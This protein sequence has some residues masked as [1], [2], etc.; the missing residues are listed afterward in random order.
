MTG[1]LGAAVGVPYAVSNA[2]DSWGP[3]SASAPQTA[4]ANGTV[5]P[6]LLV[7]PNLV[8]PQ[9]PGSEMYRSPAPLEGRKNLPLS[10]LL[11]WG[12]SKEWIYQGWA[13]KST[14][15]A[16]PGLF[17][18]RVPVVTGGGMTDV[19]G[20][21]SYYFDNAGQLQRIRL[22]G[23]TADTT[24]LVRLATSQ[25]GMQPQLSST[26]GEQK[27]VSMERKKVRSELRTIPEGVLW[28]TSPHGSFVVDLEVNRPG[29]DYWVVRKTPELKITG[30]EGSGAA[31]EEAAKQEAKPILP[32]KAIVPNASEVQAEAASKKSSVVATP[33]STRP[34]SNIEPLRT[35]RDRFRWPD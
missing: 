27:F 20:A 6:S 5:N 21:L 7:R 30:L 24:E 35:Y 28:S 1:L 22:H 26:P 14:G 13:R 25:F 3:N 12:I 4:S 8:N 16:D 11:N 9:G 29:T 32:H 2:P 23:R 31:R 18:I 15:L 19:A 33:A 17:G 10:E 34:D